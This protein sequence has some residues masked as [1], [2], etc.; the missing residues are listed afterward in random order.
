M[1]QYQAIVIDL[2]QL[3][4][5]MARALPDL[6]CPECCGPIH[7]FIERGAAVYQEEWEWACFVQVLLSVCSKKN[8]RNASG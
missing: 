4:A 5:L 6:E 7:D 1:D 3:A 2:D 8:T